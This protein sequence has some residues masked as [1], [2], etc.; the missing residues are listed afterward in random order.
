MT[1][2]TLTAE[3]QAL[4]LVTSPIV[5]S[6]DRKSLG[7]SVAFSAEWDGYA[8]SAI[9][10]TS[11][12]PDRVYEVILDNGACMVPHEAVAEADN[13]FI[14]V[15]GVIADSGTVKTSTLVKYVVNPG[16]RSGNETATDPSPDVYQQLLTAYDLMH[17][18]LDVLN[19]QKYEGGITVETLVFN[20]TLGTCTCDSV[21]VYTNGVNALIDIKNLKW[22]TTATGWWDLAELPEA[23]A[24]FANLE[25]S[26]T[27]RLQ[28]LCD[29]ETTAK[30]AIKNNTLQ[31]YV[32][33]ASTLKQAGAVS[34]Q[35][36]YAL[37]YPALDELTDMRAGAD[38]KTY[39]TA[40]LAVRSQLSSILESLNRIST[41]TI[42]H[43]TFLG[44]ETERVGA[45]GMMLTGNA[46]VD[47]IAIKPGHQMTRSHVTDYG[48]ANEV[49]DIRPLVRGMQ[50]DVS[51]ND[52]LKNLDSM[53]RY[54][55]VITDRSHVVHSV[56]YLSQISSSNWICKMPVDGYAY[57][58]LA[59][60]DSSKPVYVLKNGLY[61]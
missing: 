33:N 13:L 53:S 28:L 46:Y 47:L 32:G 27:N 14:G 29:D 57:I 38:Y 44:W 36:Q 37:R 31:I 19:G 18:R 10:F 49:A 51:E 48:D 25:D 58:Y 2:I 12:D 9:F 50:I 30:F 52:Y 3:D 45:S 40:G 54:G 1:T 41:M 15:R 35:M 7:I 61:D 11:T 55:V 8:K 4:A 22:A 6:G 59:Y 39:D 43:E 20:P 17:G 23:L 24:P 60:A 5:A 26:S 16:A 21:R 34:F 42:S 56:V